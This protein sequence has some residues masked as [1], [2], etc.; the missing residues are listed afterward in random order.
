MEWPELFLEDEKSYRTACCQVKLFFEGHERQL[1]RIYSMGKEIEGCYNTLRPFFHDYTEAIC[2][3]CATPC[4]VNRHGFPDFDDLV[5]FNSMRIK[6]PEYNFNVIDTN[7]CQFL[8]KDGCM[9]PRCSRSYR[10][11]WY[12]CDYL[13]DEFEHLHRRMFG[14]FNSEM[15]RLGEK[16][17][18]LLCQFKRL[19]FEEGREMELDLKSL[20]LL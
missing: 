6:I 9:L 5:L 3:C 10:C 7:T 8:T 18:M 16:R 4:C 19:W 1:S 12:F 17:G 20:K 15:N 14:K 2:H 11:T 13:M